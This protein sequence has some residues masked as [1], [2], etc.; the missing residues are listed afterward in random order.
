MINSNKSIFERVD[1]RILEQIKAFRLMDDN[2]MTTVFGGD[3]KVTEF[4]LRIILDRDDLTVISSMTQEEKHNIFGRSVRLDIVAEDRDKRIY[5]IEI[6]RSDKGTEA[7]RIRYNAAMID[8]RILRKGD[9]FTDLPEL[10]IIFITEHDYLKLNRPYYKVLKHFDATDKKG[11]TIPFK[12]GVNIMYVNGKYRGNDRL[13]KLMHDFCTPNAADMYYRELAERV[14][15]H[16]QEEEGV[17]KMCRMTEA[18]GDE[19]EREGIEKG[20]K[21][22][23]LVG[24]K[25]GERLGMEKGR[26]A[27]VIE[28]LKEGKREVVLNLL[29]NGRL[30]IGEIAEISGFSVEQVQKIAS[31][32]DLQ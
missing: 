24:L 20:I 2:F 10:Y 21:K 11:Q 32:I 4:L 22:G 3:V 18:Y 6:Q 14:R 9:D 16:K 26:R 23:E 27:G 1:P 25:K 13:G 28:G 5:N 30:A 15:Y 12:D 17:E 7:R 8:S 29:K 31:R 19:R